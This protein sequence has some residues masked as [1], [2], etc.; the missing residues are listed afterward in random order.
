MNSEDQDSGGFDDA[1]QRAIDSLSRP[2]HRPS[3]TVGTGSALGLGCV[4]AVVLFVLIALAARW[5]AG[6]W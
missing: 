5:L 1:E 4:V 3:T 6:S 2:D